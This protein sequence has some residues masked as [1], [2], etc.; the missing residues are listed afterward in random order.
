MNVLFHGGIHRTGSTS[1][2]ICLE[3]NRAA[4]LEQG[5][6]YPGPLRQ[7]QRFAWALWRGEDMDRVVS[8]IEAL[9]AEAPTACLTVLS[10]EDYA[11]LARLG[12]LRK[13]AKNHEVKAHFYLRRQDYWLNSWYNL[14]IKWPFDRIK[15]RMDPDEFL[16]A[17]DDFPWIDYDW[18]LGRW[19]DVLGTEQ[20]TAAVLERGQV[21]DVT[22]D[23]LNRIGIDPAFLELEQ[24]RGNPALP[25]QTLEIA[26]HIGTHDL[27]PR[28]RNRIHRAL[29]QGLADHHPGTDIVYSPADRQAI[30]DRFAAS[31]AAAARRLGRER[32]FDEPPP[33]ADAAY[34]RF[35]DL[36]QQTLLREWVAPVIRELAKSNR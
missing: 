1:L 20:V 15:S 3:R 18:L 19:M 34:W 25:V 33:A 11:T 8:E 26:R 10:G 28:H 17:I 9:I 14:H 23:F 36:S 13:L 35:P 4:L 16:A 5:V 31:N 29:S 32:L 27:G 24:P 22:T 7:H 30:L 21:E 6:H 2:Q 12:W